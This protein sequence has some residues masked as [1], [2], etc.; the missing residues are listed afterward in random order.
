MCIQLV[1]LCLPFK[2][3]SSYTSYRLAWYWWSCLWTH[4][5]VLDILLQP[6]S[7]IEHPQ[8]VVRKGTLTQVNINPITLGNAVCMLTWLNC[9]EEIVMSLNLCF[10]NWKRK[11]EPTQAWSCYLEFSQLK[12]RSIECFSMLQKE[13]W[14]ATQDMLVAIAKAY[15]EAQLN[16]L[17]PTQT[18]SRFA[19]K[20]MT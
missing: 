13:N 6:S 2:H 20:I 15:S 3:K 9:F 8:N 17:H 19:K 7:S 14:K 18:F 1:A 11:T 10:L 4:S 5:L 16:H 12:I